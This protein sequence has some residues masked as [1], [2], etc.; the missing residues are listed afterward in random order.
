MGMESI[1]DLINGAHVPENYLI[2]T[3]S[4][5]LKPYQ[6]TVLCTTGAVSDVALVLP[7]V[8]EAKGKFYSITLVTDGGKDV[9]VNDNGD[10]SRVAF[11]AVT[12]DTAEDYILLFCDG[13]R[14]WTIASEGD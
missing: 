11:T 5:T 7:T 3:E 10:D 13:L 14:W 9:T 4:A 6:Q 2:A 8:G 1:Q 12:L